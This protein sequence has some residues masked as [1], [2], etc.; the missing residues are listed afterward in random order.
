MHEQIPMTLR[1][2]LDRTMISTWKRHLWFQHATLDGC[3]LY[4]SDPEEAAT[5][6]RCFLPLFLQFGVL[7][8][9]DAPHL[10]PKSKPKT[11]AFK[12]GHE[13]RPYTQDDLL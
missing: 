7:E 13:P 11:S 8:V 5:I 6:R 4:V 10:A 9:I 2:L 1:S 12:R 3:R